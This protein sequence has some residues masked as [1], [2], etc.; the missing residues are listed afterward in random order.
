M[1]SIIIPVYNGAQTIGRCLDS[2]TSQQDIEI[3]IVCV[4]DMST[5][6]TLDILTKYA[7]KYSYIKI[8]NTTERLGPSHARNLGIN[9]IRGDFYTFIDADDTISEYQ[10]FFSEAIAT[11][12]TYEADLLCYGYNKIS[13][14]ETKPMF[15]IGS[16]ELFITEMD[17]KTTFTSVAVYTPFNIQGY[18]W[19]K[20]WRKNVF[21]PIPRFN[22][23][24]SSYEDMLWVIAACRQI[25]KAIC[26]NKL[27]YNY[28]YNPKS[29]T[30]TKDAFYS[31]RK[32]AHSY[33]ALSIIITAGIE[34]SLKND[35]LQAIRNR[36][37]LAVWD[38]FKHSIRSKQLKTISYRL[39]WGVLQF[40]Y[41]RP[42]VSGPELVITTTLDS[43]GKLPDPLILSL[44]CSNYQNW[45][46]YIMVPENQY[47][48]TN[49]YIN[50]FYGFS[51]KIHIGIKNWG[52]KENSKTISI[53]VSPNIVF[54]T[55][56]LYRIIR[57]ART[58]SKKIN[59][60]PYT[61][62]Q[63]EEHINYPSLTQID[64][65]ETFCSIQTFSDINQC[66]QINGKKLGVFVLS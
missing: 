26:F 29:I 64:S 6:S 8:I 3:E 13:Q 38:C 16:K 56:S 62:N 4:N 23:G 32:D 1:L 54:K 48:N 50:Q 14:H 59:V 2:I 19:N 22:E 41:S 42:V 44:F 27:G 61:A 63:I 17:P 9:I 10:S 66:Q 47:Q 45:Q 20:I 30:R 57:L 33:T 40:L 28:E 46:L 7:N 25:K 31:L 39:K 12:E 35:A 24:L 5:D 36:R 65:D 60:V 18:I 58:C 15:P 37:N 11:L 21:F 49:D 53:A 51:S 55:N 43:R 52:Y 34:R